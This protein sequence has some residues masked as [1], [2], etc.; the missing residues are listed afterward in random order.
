M[1]SPLRQIKIDEARQKIAVRFANSKISACVVTKSNN[2]KK[3]THPS[4]TT[5]ATSTNAG[6]TSSETLATEATASEAARSR[7]SEQSKIVAQLKNWEDTRAEDMN[8]NGRQ[9][10]LKE[11]G[12]INLKEKAAS[13][14]GK[15]SSDCSFNSSTSSTKV[16][17]KVSF[18]GDAEDQSNHESNQHTR[19]SSVH[20]AEAFYRNMRSSSRT[21][22]V[23][24]LGVAISLSR[25]ETDFIKSEGRLD[26]GLI[27]IENNENA[28]E[29]STN[30]GDTKKKSPSKIRKK[31]SDRD[32]YGDGNLGAEELFE[33]LQK[34]ATAGQDRGSPSASDP[35]GDSDLPSPVGLIEDF[36]DRNEQHLERFVANKLGA[37]GTSRNCSNV[38]D[39]KGRLITFPGTSLDDNKG[40]N[41]STIEEE[42]VNSK[43]GSIIG[44]H[45][46]R[47]QYKPKAFEDF[48][49]P[50][51][52]SH[53]DT[54]SPRGIIHSDFNGV[55]TIRA[56]SHFIHNKMSSK[57]GLK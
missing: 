48:L 13:Q 36:V 15:K 4:A 17:K 24:Q 46:N 56:H 29:S 16:P 26:E 21:D 27:L 51:F 20:N 33:K 42:E 28:T 45:S 40:L 14:K 2:D 1:C 43:T 31:P 54:M 6:T 35:D 38:M 52:G 39:Y 19:S 37:A 47:N 32:V 49:Q 25:A 50:P 3:T 34:S 44:S 9:G 53:D 22:V 5:V 30:N 10:S 18:N 7:S 23:D 8:T 41:V 12:S 11:L 57:S 55:R